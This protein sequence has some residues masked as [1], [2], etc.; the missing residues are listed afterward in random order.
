[1]DMH[2]GP[3]HTAWAWVMVSESDLTHCVPLFFSPSM[4][5]VLRP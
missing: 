5:L 2:I 1:M 4:S 3:I